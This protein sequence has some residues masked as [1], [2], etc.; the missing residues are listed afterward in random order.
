MPKGIE[1]KQCTR[2][3]RENVRLVQKWRRFVPE[4]YIEYQVPFTW[5]KSQEDWTLF[6][7]WYGSTPDLDSHND[8]VL[9]S[10]FK[11]KTSLKRFHEN[12]LILRGHDDSKVIG[13]MV[14]DR[15]DSG[16]W[17][18]KAHL[19]YDID[20][21][22][23]MIQDWV[24]KWYSIG[25]IPK[26]YEFFHIDGRSLD[27]ISESE[28][29]TI[30]IWTD[31]KR[32]ITD[33]EIYELSV[34]SLPANP[35]TLFTLSK[36][37]KSYFTELLPNDMKIT[38]EAMLEARRKALGIDVSGLEN[39]SEKALDTV[40]ETQQEEVT[41]EKEAVVEVET[42]KDEVEIKSEEVPDEEEVEETE[43]ENEEE[44]VK[45]EEEETEWDV[46]EDST[47]VEETAENAEEDTQEEEKAVAVN[48][49]EVKELKQVQEEMKGYRDEIKALR[50]E[51]K[52]MNEFVSELFDAYV[53]LTE[54]ATDMSN[55]LNAIPAKHG[56]VYVPKIWEKDAWGLKKSM[57]DAKAKA[58]V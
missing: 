11:G 20:D 24:V 18:V 25:F 57:L 17:W 50:D 42:V 54:K 41:E 23:K 47:E 12:P 13:A 56:M 44:E 26:A 14:E 1:V 34:V 53:E 2:K 49:V 51:Q 3:G 10:A 48:V 58:W 19:K 32:V 4:N 30:N 9:A 21:T 37:V 46:E 8:V 16:G 36:A 22:F 33:L 29:E 27:E 31:I 5:V 40:V 52:A 6:I 28:R 45:K 43:E 39:A 35:K 55:K 15:V 7:E 38:K